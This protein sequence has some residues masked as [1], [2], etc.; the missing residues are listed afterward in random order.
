MK[1]SRVGC[2]FKEM[3]EGCYIDDLLKAQKELP[4][5]ELYLEIQKD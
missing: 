5:N 2:L 3:M 4:D 1:V